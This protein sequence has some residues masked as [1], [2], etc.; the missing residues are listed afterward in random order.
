MS[1]GVY[2]RARAGRTDYWITFQV[3]G[4]RVRE[5]AG[6][7]QREAVRL[8]ARRLRE[9]EAGT[10]RAAGASAESVSLGVFALEFFAGRK[11]RSLTDEQACY[12][13][14]V[15]P[16]FAESYLEDITAREVAS[17]VQDL[18]DAGQLS[19][20]TIRN[21]HGVLSVML[22]QARFEGLVADNV[23]KALPRGVLPG[24]SKKGAPPYS[25]DEL[26]VMLGSPGVTPDVRVLLALMGL[27]GLRLGEACGRRWGDLD[28]TAKP[29]W[30]LHV[31][32]QYDRQ[33]L[34]GQRPGV[35]ADRWVPIHPVLQDIL[36][37]WYQEGF[38]ALLGRRPTKDDPISPWPRNLLPRM[39]NQAAKAVDRAAAAAGIRRLPGRRAHSLRRSFISLLRSDGVLK[40]VVEVITHNAGGHT[41]DRYTWLGW[42][43]LCGAVMKL[44]IVPAA[45]LPE[46]SR[47]DV[48]ELHD[49]DG[50][51]RLLGLQKRS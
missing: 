12:R 49:R 4:R 6:T 38:Q 35:S 37:D 30:C 33:P 27:G 17:W 45:E 11:T 31:H 20:K 48:A 39:E 2:A 25:R 44:E 26:A 36:V 13:N 19:P 3:D 23:A 10:Y 9:V 14:H 15:A 40:E 1:K 29:L 24:T 47:H 22:Q 28:T 21:V 41:I 43:A 7:D 42:D 50:D 18:L 51:D 8:R 32:D 34:K 5:C 16:R 46:G